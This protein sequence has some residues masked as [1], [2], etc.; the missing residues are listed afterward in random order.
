MKI[1]LGGN[2]SMKKNIELKDFLKM[3][4]QA[5]QKM[6]FKRKI[7]AIISQKNLNT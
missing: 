1:N 2:H 4:S 3:Q 6:P 7:Y 5:Q